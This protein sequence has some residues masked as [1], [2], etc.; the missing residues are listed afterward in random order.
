MLDALM[1]RAKTSAVDAVM[2]AGE[3]V[4]RDGRF[5]RID[6]DAILNEI[7]QMLAKPRDAQEQAKRELGAAVFPHVKAFY[8]D[9]FAETPAR[10]PFY[11]P[12]SRT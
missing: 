2:I 6:R 8:A 5:T 12:S 9:Y 11:A 4:Y 1:Q 10:Q 7:E 3:V